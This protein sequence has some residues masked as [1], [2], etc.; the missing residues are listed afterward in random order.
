MSSWNGLE[1]F[2]HQISAKF[3]NVKAGIMAVAKK[4]SSSLNIKNNADK[5]TVKLNK[6]VYLDPD[7]K[8]LW[9]KIKYKTT[10]SVSLNSE[11]LIEKCCVDMQKFLDV[12]GSKLIYSKAK[13]DINEGGVSVEKNARYNVAAGGHT[14]NIPDII[15]YLQNETNLTRRTIVEILTKS[16]TLNSFKLNPQKYMEQTAHIIRAKMSLMIV[17]GI[18]YTRIGDDAYYAQELFE[19]E[20]LT[21]YL[22]KNILPSERSVYDHIVYDSDTEMVFAQS[23]ENNPNIKVYAKLPGWFKIDTPIGSY[24]PDW[25]VLVDDGINN[26]LY[27]VVESKAKV[28]PGAIRETEDKKIDCGMKHFQAIHTGTIFKATD[29]PGSIA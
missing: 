27:F 8:D 29:D 2:V 3:D 4:V 12:S 5:T 1:I 9:D 28:G 18:R 16:G 14:G 26:K 7:F 15:T 17:D 19:T 21:G 25:A 13:L 10:Y 6:Q 20:E 11:K 22:N 24:N 23:F